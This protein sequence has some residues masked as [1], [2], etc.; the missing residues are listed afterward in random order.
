M[1]KEKKYKRIG[2]L[3]S[4]LV[5]VSMLLLFYFLVAWKEPFPP[6]PTY[7]I[8][9]NFGFEQSG[10][11][12]EAQ[13]PASETELPAETEPI[14]EPV[15]EVIPEPVEESVVEPEADHE[16]AIVDEPDFEEVESPDV[17]PEQSS[18]EVETEQIVETI[19][20][21]EEEIKEEPEVETQNESEEIETEALMPSNNEKGTENQS[22]GES[23][24]GGDEGKEEGTIDGRAIY[25]SQGNSEGASL[26]MAGWSWDFKPEPDDKSFEAG[27]IVYKIIIDA[28]GY[29][30][31]IDI[32]SSTVSPDV[33]R[34]Y[35]QSVER[36]S[37]S[38]T[39]EYK[40]APTSTGYVTFI[41]R[42][43]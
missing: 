33:E 37:F 36:L 34:V 42:T 31:R 10:R 9:L 38:K 39:N 17:I 4:F 15:E 18:E 2:W 5:Q 11:G 21:V 8:E 32:V 43:K 20:E 40:S 41:I 29:L 6:I 13:Q 26:Q 19:P 7:G 12:E 25:G 14:E 1:E 23:E 30:S 3:T 22:Q 16:E 27:K 35:R 28:D 24:P